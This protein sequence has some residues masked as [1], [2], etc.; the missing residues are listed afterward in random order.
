MYIHILIY[1]HTLHTYTISTYVYPPEGG[2]SFCDFGKP[3]APSDVVSPPRND[4]GSDGSTAD[5]CPQWSVLSIRCNR[6]LSLIF[7]THP[8]YISAV[9]FIDPFYP[10]VLTDYWSVIFTIYPLHLLSIRCIY[11]CNLHWSVLSIRCDRFLIRYIY[12]LS[13]IFTIHPFY[14]SV[15][16]FTN[17][18]YV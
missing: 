12:N 1:M 2:Q 17:P 7:T 15:I 8:L 5:R 16:T 4:A 3:P 10:S 11:R 14:L 9:T 13:V 18:L 6:H